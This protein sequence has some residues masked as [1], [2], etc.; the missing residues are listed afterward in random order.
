MP[1]LKDIT[2]T[3][4]NN[5]Q[6]VDEHSQKKLEETK[7]N[8][9]TLVELLSI[10]LE[11]TNSLS[12]SLLDPVLDE[13][14]IDLH[15]ALV[16]ALAGK[17]KASLVLFRTCL[18]ISIYVIYFV[19]HP[20]EARLWADSSK[21]MSFCETTKELTSVN[22]ILATYCYPDIP[23][24]E[25]FTPESIEKE[26]SIIRKNLLKA[27]SQFSE[28]VHGKYLF[29]QL[30]EPNQDD[31]KNTLESFE[32]LIEKAIKS[33]ASLIYIRMRK[34]KSIFAR[35]PSISKIL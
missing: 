32:S 3:L 11:N 23:M 12:K 5:C 4:L 27:Y 30:V 2:Q 28:R 31:Y 9:N 24:E 14:F 29:L 8:C 17:F 33:L 26:L 10:L 21:D 22:Y 13:L 25:D 19:D 6:K 18:E 34:N 35:I 16:L 15:L 1:S 20:I 7:V